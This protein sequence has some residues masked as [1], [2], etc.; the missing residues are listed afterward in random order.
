M[1]QASRIVRR[2]VLT[3]ANVNEST[4]A[5]A[6]I[7]GDEAIVYADRAYDSRQRR[8]H[9]ADL[10]IRDGIARKRDRW[11]ALGRWAVR[12]NAVIARRRA[13]I[14]SLFALLKNVYRFARAPYRGLVRNAA[15]LHLTLAAMNLRR[16]ARATPAPA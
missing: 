1:D 12:R 7:C 9:L 4:A 5:D 10:G 11:H 14:E 2:A 6:L 16:W 15:G 13:P 8:Q 3:P